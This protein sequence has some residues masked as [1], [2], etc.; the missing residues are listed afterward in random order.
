MADYTNILDMFN[1]I[2]NHKY[3]VEI[4]DDS[5]NRKLGFKCM[6]TGRIWKIKLTD[7]KDSLYKIRLANEYL[8]KYPE[9]WY[10]TIEDKKEL[11]NILNEDKNDFG[12]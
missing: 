12:K 9:K 3:K 7:L 1:D 10:E 8:Q 6:T 2:E 4:F 5:I 11:L